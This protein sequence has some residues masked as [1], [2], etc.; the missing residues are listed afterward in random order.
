MPTRGVAVDSAFDGWRWG[1]GSENGGLDF[2]WDNKIFGR[3][4]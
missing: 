4:E 3:V 1:R 2:L